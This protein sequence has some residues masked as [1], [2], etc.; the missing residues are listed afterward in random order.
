M[1]RSGLALL[2]LCSTTSTAYADIPFNVYGAGSATCGTWVTARKAVADGYNVREL[3]LQ[4][5]MQG[6][7]SAVGGLYSRQNVAFR[8]SDITAMSMWIDNYC[9]SNPLEM[10]INAVWKLT[11]ALKVR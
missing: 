4:Q 10:F 5:W 11:E 3:V 9:Q 6:Y 7:I 1:K 8:D 2:L